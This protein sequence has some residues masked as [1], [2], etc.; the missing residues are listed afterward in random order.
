MA[1]RFWRRVSIAPGLRINLSQSGAS[2]SVGRRGAWLTTG[3]RGQRATI[4]LPGS[5]L[6]LTEKLSAKKKGSVS[7]SMPW[8][9]ISGIA[10]FSII[11]I[12]AN[13]H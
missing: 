6:F 10:I 7:T 9:V 1:V 8:L 3:P 4:G 12:M 2:V 11:V 5:G 13:N